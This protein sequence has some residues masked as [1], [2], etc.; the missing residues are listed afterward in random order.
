MAVPYFFDVVCLCS[1]AQ[2]KITVSFLFLNRIIT[3]L[4]DTKNTLFVLT[5]VKDLMNSFSSNVSMARRSA[6]SSAQRLRA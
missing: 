1:L 3:L 5:F 4:R 2:D 6:P